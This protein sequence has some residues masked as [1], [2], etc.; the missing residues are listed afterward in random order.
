[1]GGD[2]LL[3][4]GLLLIVFD[5][6]PEALAAHPLAVHVD[7]EGLLVRM[8]DHLGPHMLKVIAQG[9]HRRGVQG[10]DPLPVPSR[11]TG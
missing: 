8:L 9:P 4:A 11:S 2:L 6:F 3:D 5:E 7:E 10:D 1:M